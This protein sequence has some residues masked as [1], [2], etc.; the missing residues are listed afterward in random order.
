[1]VAY[2]S[3][4]FTVAGPIEAG[5]VFT[6]RIS[7]AVLLCAGEDVVPV[8]GFTDPFYFLAC[9][10]NGGH[11]TNEVAVAGFFERIAVQLA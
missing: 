5:M 9:F 10:V 3:A 2:L 11:F 6:V 8:G 4:A 7:H 1:M